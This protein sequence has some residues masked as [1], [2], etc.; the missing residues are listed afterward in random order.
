M[1]DGFTTLMHCSEEVS[2]DCFLKLAEFVQNLGRGKI[3]AGKE[4]P[5]LFVLRLDAQGGSHLAGP[6]SR[7]PVLGLRLAQRGFPLSSPCIASSVGLRRRS[8][9]PPRTVCRGRRGG[10]HSTCQL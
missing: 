9:E 8:G 4:M 1:A 5:I 3:L 7:S 10:T 6:I 2:K